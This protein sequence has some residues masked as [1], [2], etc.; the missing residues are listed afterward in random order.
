MTAKYWFEEELLRDYDFEP[1]QD[2]YR[3]DDLKENDREELSGMLY[4]FYNAMNFF[5]NEKEE[6]EEDGLLGKLRQEYLDDVKDRLEA[7]AISDIDQYILSV[8][9]SYE[10]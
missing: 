10:E 3:I 1:W 9:D 5:E 2:C 6:N 7:V 4:A 8:L